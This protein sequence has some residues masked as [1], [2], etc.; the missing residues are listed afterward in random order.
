[1]SR[2]W[3][4]LA[5]QTHVPEEG[6]MQRSLIRGALAMLAGAALLS[7]CSNDRPAPTES[8]NSP[9]PSASIVPS[10]CPTVLQTSQLIVA[11]FPQKSV[12]RTTATLSYAAI[13]LAINTNHQ[14]DARTL[15]FKL[16]DFTFKQ[17]AAGKLI[18]GYSLTTRQ[19]LLAFETG[20]YCTVGLP[21][22]GLTLPGD[23]T[24]SG[25]VNTV[26]FPSTTV[27]TV[28]TRDGNAGVKFPPNSFTGPAVVVTISALTEA[29]H[30]LN[31]SLD[32]YGPFYDVKVSP[33][34]AITANLTVGLCLASG[35]EIPTVFLAHNVIQ[36][37]NDA[38]TP[39]IEVLPPGL[40]IGE[41][42][43]PQRV[44]LSGRQLLDLAMH[45]DVGR[46][47][48]ALGSA[49]ADLVLPTSAYAAT[50]GKTGLT[51][52]FS[53][54][55]GVDTKVYLTTNPSPFPAQTAPAGSAVANPPSALVS[56]QLGAKV[57]RVSVLFSVTEGGGRVA[58]GTSAAVTTNAV[59]VATVSDWVITSGPNS[60]Q[61]VGTFADP[62]V[63][64]A[65]APAGIDFPQS[66]AVAPAA[67]VTYSATGTDVIPYGASYFY[68]DGPLGHDPGFAAPEFSTT[69][70]T[71]GNGPF[72][73]GDVGGTVCPLNS[74][75]GF[76]L[77]HAWASGTDLL[78]RK[79]FP[80]PSWWSAPL[81]ITVAIDNDVQLFVNGTSVT[82][83]YQF[84]GT[85]AA[86]YSFDSETGFVTHENCATKGSLT[87]TVPAGVLIGGQN[88]LAIRAR[89]RGSV[90]YVDA[91]V[92][93]PVPA[94]PQTF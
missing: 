26:V 68:L 14:A 67:G 34:S 82:A 85:D 28:L 84:S 50:G 92:T 73:T 48:R 66:V 33:E 39:G 21:T 31:T 57:A 87:F 6:I 23:P 18:G 36:T 2:K 22:T 42:C 52:T 3:L 70:W 51:K 55:G 35:V 63:T 71:F 64:F 32:Q 37:V 94:P 19:N 11:L 86:N 46:A 59:G 76:T 77:N 25:T 13:L 38:P 7:A 89:D 9:P 49:L 79:T 15:M 91:K 74:E 16:M 1:M 65:A 40:T 69:S 20:L 75:S 72:G 93:A 60:V 54:F 80:L 24:N 41:L 5:G 30:P 43:T 83:S 78:L 27:Q 58:G 29:T 88:T 12:A 17:F 61:G 8:G 53:P 56:T 90:N 62:T 47:S 4:S 10:G 81:T 44:S 45:G